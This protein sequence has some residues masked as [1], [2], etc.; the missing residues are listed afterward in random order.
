MNILVIGNGGREHAFAWKIRQSNLCKNL[1]IA[2]GNA[3]TGLVGENVPIAVDDFEALGKF[4]LTKNINLV[5]VGPEGPLVKGIRDY[6]ENNETL[7]AIGLVGPG[8]EGAQLEGSK[9]FSKQFMVRNGVPTAKA[10]TFLAHESK[11]AVHYLDSCKPPI[12]LKADGLAAGKG[13][14][15]TDTVEEAKGAIREMLEDKKFGEA[16]SKVLVE[17][18]LD[19]IE[20][21]VFVLTDGESITFDELLTEIENI[22]YSGTKLNLD[23]YIDSVLDEDKQQQIY[24]YFLESETDSIEDAVD[25]LKDE[26]SDFTEDNLRL[27]RVK[28]LSE[29]AN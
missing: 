23:Y 19:G 16:S 8:K 21:S 22:C 2:P 26:D 14:I 28:F 4:C 13:V 17:E 6:F 3:G 10:R 7:R 9:D 18:F 20:L 15:I 5:I 11:E 27:M 24:D 25:A 12:V 29:Y 1:F